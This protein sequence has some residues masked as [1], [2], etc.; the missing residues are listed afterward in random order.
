[1]VDTAFPFEKILPRTLFQ[2][3]L[4]RSIGNVKTKLSG[5]EREKGKIKFRKQCGYSI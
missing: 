2:Y 3:T 4:L 1:M 5:I